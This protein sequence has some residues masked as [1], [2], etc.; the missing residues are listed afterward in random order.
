[1]NSLKS[2]KKDAVSEIQRERDRPFHQ[3]KKPRDGGNILNGC[4]MG[5]EVE[6]ERE[7]S[8]KMECT[9]D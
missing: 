5:V 6:R 3:L 8:I 9:P 7:R 4:S 2:G 1:M